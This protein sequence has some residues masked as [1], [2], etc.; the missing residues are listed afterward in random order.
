[1]IVADR[2]LLREAIK[3]VI[4]SHLPSPVVREA[5]AEEE[6]I[7]IL[8][9]KSVEMAILDIGLPDSSGVTMLKRIKRLCPS[10]KCLVLTRHDNAQYTRLARGHGGSDYLTKGA[11]S[12]Q[13]SDAIRTILFGRRVRMDP[14]QASGTSQI[15]CRINAYIKMEVLPMPKLGSLLLASRQE[16]NFCG[17]CYSGGHLG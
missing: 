13:L 11:T 12:W 5:A 6:A 4:E 14:F 2:P 8:R 15:T 1:V 3:P 7:R 10:R 17:G 9:A 16:L